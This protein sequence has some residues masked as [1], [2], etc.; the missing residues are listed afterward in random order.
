[1][2]SHFIHTDTTITALRLS[3]SD[4]RLQKYLEAHAGDYEA[5]IRLYER[6]VRLS[7]AFYTPLQCLEVT[8]RNKLGHTLSDKFGQDW[9]RD[10]AIPLDQDA[11]ES[12]ASAI[13]GVE[14]GYVGSASTGA[15][16]AELSLGFWV[17][18]LGQRYDHTLFRTVL[19]RAFKED[20]KN[21]ARYRIHGRLNMIRR[22]RNRIAQHEPIFLRNLLQDH[23]EIIEAI[24]WLC[25]VTA[26]WAA[27]NSRVL[28]VLNG[29]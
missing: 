23:T 17:A 14:R 19:F 5:A 29:G 15:I 28:A 12:I 8:L 20:G 7:E 6:N 2:S 27:H 9:P 13:R 10:H 3:I 25:P 18:L 21:M 26:A 22:F 1:M 4:E 11:H 24:G 16:V